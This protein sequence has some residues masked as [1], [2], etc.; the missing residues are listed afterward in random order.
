MS[1]CRCGAAAHYEHL[2]R[3]GMPTDVILNTAA[4]H[5]TLD[6]KGHFMRYVVGFFVISMMSH[7]TAAERFPR[8]SPE[9]QGV[10]SSAILD[11][12]QS[13]DRQIDSMNSFMMVR[14]GHVIAQGWWSPYTA[15]DPHMLFSLSKSFTSTAIGI[16]IEEGRLSLDDT[17]LSFFPEDA[18]DDPS[19]NVKAMRIR[20]LLRMSTGHHQEDLSQFSFASDGRLTREFLALP[21]AHKPGTHFLYNTPATYMCSAI[22]QKV[23]G[24]KLIDYLR[25]RL[26]AP[27]GIDH[28]TWS[29]SAQGICHGGY[30]LSI[31]T[32]DIAAFGQMYLQKGEWHQEQLVP[33]AWVTA[34]TSRQTSNG[35]DPRSDWEQG[36]GYQFWQCRHHAYRGD[37]AYGQY[38]LVM[39][40]QDTVIAITAGLGNM[41]SVLDLIW[42]KL[43]PELRAVA[44]PPHD[45]DE[46][47]LRTALAN[48]VLTIPTGDATSTLAER[49][50][51]R[52]YAFPANDLQLKSVSFDFAPA[53]TVLKFQD[54]RGEHRLVCGNQ[55]WL[56]SR[57]T[58]LGYLESRVPD[59]SDVGVA[60]SGA[61][62]SDHVYT[63][64]VCMYE[65]PFYQDLVF[66]FADRQ[67]TYSSR[68]NVGIGSTEQ[69]LLRGEAL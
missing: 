12:V 32:E 45:T 14:H 16:A 34:A 24:E 18:P 11:F 57:M 69:M 36:Y 17:V 4:A 68:N 65:T 66:D 55:K 7:L 51:D 41:Q 64:R 53:Q 59:G 33:S 42:D 10:P 54:D 52:T 48:L 20:D 5:V 37:G 35:S 21:V 19:N 2:A 8:S 44:L 25:P 15:D 61:W 67:V 31:T 23:T 62:T 43:L 22:V 60:A 13:A 49:L 6:R 47:Q 28:A 50:R 30:G 9:A 58:S 26:F 46:A 3:A 38:C 40:E 39:P 29:L 63:I 56:R 27:L 1:E